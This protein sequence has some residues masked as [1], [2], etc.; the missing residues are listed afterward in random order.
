M[1]QERQ[2]CA[3]NVRQRPPQLLLRDHGETVD[4]WIDQKA[5]ESPHSSGRKISN[6]ILIVMNHAAP[7]RP[8]DAA[9]AFCGRAL[10]LQCGSRSCR[11]KAVEWHIN[12]QRVSAGG[13]GS[14]RGFE[15]F[16]LR[17]TGI[18]DMHVRI[19]E[20]R[21]NGRFAEVMD[22]VAINRYLT[23]R[24]NCLDTLSFHQDGRR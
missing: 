17:A 18:V 16:P 20:P 1:H 12:K 8:I 24:N 11:G 14:R 5:F 13:R 21:K 2:A 15:T 22:F 4:T 9:S 23:G 19:D 10:G 3:S 6:V 7:R